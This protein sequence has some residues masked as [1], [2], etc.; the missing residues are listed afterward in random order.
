VKIFVTGSTGFIGSRLTTKLASEGH[1]IHALYRSENKI[2]KNLSPAIKLFKGDITDETSLE[3]AMS[4]CDAVFHVAAFAAVWHRDVREIYRL[5]VDSTV[6]ILKI[7][8]RSGVQRCVVTSSAAVFGPSESA[9]LSE[10]S[11]LPAGFFTPYER[12][13]AMM[14]KEIA[15]LT[16]AGQDIVLVN[17]T[18][19]YGP[20]PLNDAN[21]VTRLVKMYVEGKWHFLPGSGKSIGN[22]VYVDDVVNGH[23][24][25]LH[26]GLPGERYILGGENVS[27]ID[28]FSLLDELAGKHYQLFRFPLSMM[29]MSAGMMTLFA[30]M[31]GIPPMITPGLVKKYNHHWKLTSEKARTVL[32]YSPVSLK[33]GLKSTLQWLAHESTV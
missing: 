20:G 16:A 17:P 31:T 19:L 30:S 6:S 28:L 21:S 8:A 18:R 7:A 29:L 5:N 14:E 25:A 9:I 1:I 24:L 27:Y 13:K 26:K 22:Y 12:S 23:I 3:K 15:G 11:S 32:G 33:E 2:P 10:T 4:G